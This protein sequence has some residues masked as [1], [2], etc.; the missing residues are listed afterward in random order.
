MTLDEAMELARRQCSSPPDYHIVGT[1]RTD[2]LR[3]ILDEVERLKGERD[4]WQSAAEMREHQVDDL[5]R[6]VRALQST[7]HEDVL[8]IGKQRDAAEARVKAL[9]DALRDLAGRIERDERIEMRHLAPARAALEP[10]P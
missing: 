7:P 3:L 5:Q 2:G 10:K 6:D 9:E 8:A 1:L 4:T